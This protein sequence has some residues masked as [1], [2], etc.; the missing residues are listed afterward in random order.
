[1][2]IIL[3]LEPAPFRIYKNEEIEKAKL[4]NLSSDNRKITV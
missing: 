1:M 2:H 3:Q 4:E